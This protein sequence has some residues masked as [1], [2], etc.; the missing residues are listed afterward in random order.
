MKI[1][2]TT[3]YKRMARP[4]SVQEL[5]EDGAPVLSMED[6]ELEVG[7]RTAN[8]PISGGTS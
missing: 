1:E 3:S 4:Y 7:L 6:P 5:P 8:D 2:R